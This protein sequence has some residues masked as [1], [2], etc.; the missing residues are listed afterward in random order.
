MW[1]RFGVGRPGVGEGGAIVWPPALFFLFSFGG[2][3]EPAALNTW[4]WEPPDRIKTEAQWEGRKG[5]PSLTHKTEAP[6]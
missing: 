1:N 4:L 5:V 3:L 2:C 6:S